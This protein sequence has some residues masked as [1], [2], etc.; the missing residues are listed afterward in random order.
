MCI[1]LFY[2]SA[3]A[4]V[5]LVVSHLFFG[6][7][8]L[9]SNAAECGLLVGVCITAGLG[10]LLLNMGISGAG[11]M[12][13]SFATLLEPVTAVLCGILVL[14]E[15]VTFYTIVGIVLILLAVWLN[16][17]PQKNTKREYGK[18]PSTHL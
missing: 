5:L 12:Q 7:F 13:A 16:A 14:H 10:F 2:M 6:A 8:R 9:P 1:S 11:A 18:F 3:S 15:K 17:L 4:S